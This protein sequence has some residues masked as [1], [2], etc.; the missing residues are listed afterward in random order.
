M[1]FVMDTRA[2]DSPFVQA[3]WRAH[4]ERPGTFVSVAASHW[5][6]V[7]TRREGATTTLIVRGPETRATPLAY[8]EGGEWW[9]IRFSLGTFIPLLPI[10]TL[11]DRAVTL[12]AAGSRSFWL[13][14]ADWPFPEYEQADAFVDRLVHD[15]LLVR[16]PMV[17]AAVQ[18][19]LPDYSVRSVQRRFMQVTGLT[20][21]TVR[22]I[23]RAR[24]AMA[25][26]QRG[27]PILDVV[28]EAG[29]YDQPH[30][31]RALRR[32]LGQTPAQIAGQRRVGELS[33]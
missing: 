31:T 13:H 8:S 12:P 22:Q 15:G 32:W 10:S 30:L 7:V 29:Y 19:R 16:D 4:S 18:G 33:L 23:G 6:L 5:E 24:H 2:A 1:T 9:G 26:L 27:V 3:F 17:A 28:H 25:L 21:S 14:G 11:V 20:Q